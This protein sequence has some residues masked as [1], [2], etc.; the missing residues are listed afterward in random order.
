[1]RYIDIISK[2]NKYKNTNEEVIKPKN[3]RKILF[4]ELDAAKNSKI[5]N[6]N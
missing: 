5:T 2:D 6:Q 4:D 3:R 1:M